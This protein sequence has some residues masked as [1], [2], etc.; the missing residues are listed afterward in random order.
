MNIYRMLEPA[1]TQ[2]WGIELLDS[3]TAYFGVLILLS[4][5]FSGRKDKKWGQASALIICGILQIWLSIFPNDWFPLPKMILILANWSFVSIICFTGPIWKQALVIFL[6]WAIVFALRFTVFMSVSTVGTTILNWSSRMGLSMT[7]GYLL[8][9][10]VS[11]SIVLF[12]SFG[13][14]YAVRHLGC[15][16][17]KN[18]VG[19]SYLLFIP[20]YTLVAAGALISNAIMIDRR[21]SLGVISLGGGLALISFILCIAIYKL[22]KNRE[23]EAEK[24]KL[25]AEA[26]HNLETAK[27]Y[28]ESF[29][30]QRRITHDFRNQLDTI[31][32]LLESKEFERAADYVQHLQ[33]TTQEIAPAIRTNHPIADAILNQK[34]QQAAQKGIGMLL[35]C[36][37]LSAISLEDGDLVTLL[38]NILD[39]AIAASAQTK[40]KDIRV[41]LWQ[42][43]GVYQFVVRNSCL[44]TPAARNPNEQ[45][46]HGF[47]T[48]L[49]YAVLDKYHYPYS[50][51]RSG[52]TYIF[53][54]IIG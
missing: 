34:Y 40:E 23:A 22:E 52:T 14:G 30:Q 25:Q 24:Q 12:V 53:A 38:G 51:N 3:A 1:A 36:N 43:Q 11:W 21:L 45:F 5:F 37:D 2:F 18:G 6:Y 7:D 42:E 17:G 50:A 28:Q 54:A 35:S 47:G 39:N 13:S 19:G 32:S 20:L 46:L 10:L 41:R 49:A 8:S 44:E 33:C 26:A 9:M 16:Q 48:G 29:N 15:R 4:V 31:Q 27:N